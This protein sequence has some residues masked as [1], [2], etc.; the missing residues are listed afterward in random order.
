MRKRP[1][2]CIFFLALGIILGISSNALAGS[3][4]PN[5]E[6]FLSPPVSP[7]NLP[8]TTP[9]KILRHLRGIYDE[10]KEMGPRKGDNFIKREFF[11]EIDGCQENKEEQVVV[12]IYPDLQLERM[13]I[14]IT[15]FSSPQLKFTRLAKS[16]KNISCAFLNNDLTLTS[17]DYDEK[18]TEHF[19]KAIL[20]GIKKEKKLLSLIKKK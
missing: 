6:D 16:T 17:T 14:Q 7:S 15:S 10:V 12:L 18:E 3:L 11:I 4:V 13:L 5:L 20:E 1:N 19:L 9:P 2:F 8:P